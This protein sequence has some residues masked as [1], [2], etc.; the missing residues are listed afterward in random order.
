MSKTWR[1][2]DLD[3]KLYGSTMP[4]DAVRNLRAAAALEILKGCVLMTP[5][6]TGRARGNWQTNAG[7]PAEGFV[8][9]MKDKQ[10]GSTIQ[11]GLSVISGEPDPYVPIWLHNGVPYI[12]FLDDRFHMVDVTVERVVATLKGGT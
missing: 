9:D 11:A 6:D 8:D 2:F 7:A 5:V 12:E 3:L 1:E 4:A 10:G